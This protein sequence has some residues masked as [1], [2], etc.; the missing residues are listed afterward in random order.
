VAAEAGNLKVLRYNKKTLFLGTKMKKFIFLTI[1]ILIVN[2]C[3]GSSKSY[4]DNG[5]INNELTTNKVTKNQKDVASAYDSTVNNNFYKNNLNSSNRLYK[6]TS[7]DIESLLLCNKGNV[8]IT[9][10]DKNITL[11]FYNC[12]SD[13]FNDAIIYEGS[14]IFVLE[15]PP[16]TVISNLNAKFNDTQYKNYNAT[17]SFKDLN[18][19]IKIDGEIK[20]KCSNNW[21]K[22]NSEDF[23]ITYNSYQADNTEASGKIIIKTDNKNIIASFNNNQVTIN[24]NNNTTTITIDKLQEIINKGCD[25]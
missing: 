14:I 12:Q 5:V 24:D 15:N 22:I 9:Q 3:G 2:N 16:K 11:T 6:I 10:E 1:A 20:T 8:D 19:T 13:F 21:L 4:E 23:N 17:I 18:K 7:L 25:N